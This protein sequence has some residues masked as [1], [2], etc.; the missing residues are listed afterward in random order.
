MIPR[1]FH[2]MWLL[3]HFWRGNTWAMNDLFHFDNIRQELGIPS[4]LE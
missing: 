1:K 3:E 4:F 2:L